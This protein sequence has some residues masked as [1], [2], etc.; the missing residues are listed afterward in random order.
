ME[1]IVFKGEGPESINSFRNDL[2]LLRKLNN[3]TDAFFTGFE[4]LIFCLALLQNGQPEDLTEV[5]SI[6]Q[7]MQLQQS[8]IYTPSYKEITL[9]A[10]SPAQETTS[11]GEP[12]SNCIAT[13]FMALRNCT[14]KGRLSN[15]LEAAC[16]D[17]FE[18]S[19]RNGYH[20]LAMEFAEMLGRTTDI[21]I[22]KEF[23][24][25]FQNRTKV[26]TIA[27]C[28][29]HKTRWQ[30]A[31]SDLSNLSTILGK[32]TEAGTCRIAWTI[33]ADKEMTSIF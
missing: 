8:N 20:W 1:E 11:P 33:Q 26:M 16:R 3:R 4:G 14:I 25:D 23:S 12:P 32:S 29:K 17:A 24:L 10:D 19:R 13:L 22:Y 2:S 28:I 18:Q 31:L 9:L 6:S 5:K 21:G 27:N 7:T 15:T 30:L